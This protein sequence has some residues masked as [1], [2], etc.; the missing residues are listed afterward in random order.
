[1]QQWQKCWGH[2]SLSETTVKV[3]LGSHGVLTASTIAPGEQG[4]IT[5]FTKYTYT[6]IMQLTQQ[7]KPC[8]VVTACIED[9]LFSFNFF[10]CQLNFFFSLSFIKIWWVKCKKIY[11]QIRLQLFILMQHLYLWEV[12]QEDKRSASWDR[13]MSARWKP[14]KGFEDCQAET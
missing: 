10:H 12:W 8:M 1:M 13:L 3:F 5:P 9:D 14:W 6:V 11:I 2:I 4:T 7:Q